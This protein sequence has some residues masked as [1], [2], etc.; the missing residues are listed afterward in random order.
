MV[1]IFK[2]SAHIV[3][4]E[5]QQSESRHVRLQAKYLRI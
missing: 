5:K 1:G 4:Y 3:I 2:E